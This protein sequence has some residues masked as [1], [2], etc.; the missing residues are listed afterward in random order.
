MLMAGGVLF[1]A[2]VLISPVVVRTLGSQG[3]IAK[4]DNLV[5][6]PIAKYSVRHPHYGDR[7]P[8]CYYRSN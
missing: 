8:F 2:T 7:S 3:C 5:T 1:V 4:R 6:M